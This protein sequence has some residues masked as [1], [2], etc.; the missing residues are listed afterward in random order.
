MTSSN[1]YGAIDIVGIR[2]SGK[3]NKYGAINVSSFK[4][5]QEE[6][7]GA[8]S[9]IRYASQFPGG[10]AEATT[11]GL[12]G[13]IW[14]MMAHGESE[15]D[16]YEEAALFE[17][18]KK[19]G[20]DFDIEEYEAERQN[21][22]ASLPTVGNISREVE[23]LTGLPL[24]PK[25]EGQELLRMGS[26]AGKFKSGGVLPKSTAA[27]A[28]PTT[29]AGLEYLGVPKEIAHPIG[30]L[31][32]ESVGRNVP[33]VKLG[34]I[35]PSGLSEK[36]YENLK[37][38]MDVPSS[39]LK[40]ISKNLETE[41]KEI[42]DK[43]IEETP[44]RDV[45]SAMKEGPAYKEKI[46]ERF[47]EVKNL[48]DELPE[49]F[50]SKAV[51]KQ[52]VDKLSEQKKKNLI[53]TE[54]EKA[55]N[56]IMKD[57]VKDFREQ[58]T[59]MSDIIQNYRELNKSR[60]D[61]FEPGKS[62]AHNEAKRK[63]YSDAAT[64]LSEVIET[65][66]PNSELN[67]L[68]KETNKEWSMIMD[69]ESIDTFIDGMF[70]GKI[71]FAKADKF[72]KKTGTSAPFERA[73]GKKGFNDFKQLMNDMM[74]KQK[75][76]KL[77]KEAED[78]GFFKSIKDKALAFMISD[79]VGYSKVAIDLGK[80]TR[81]NLK[82]YLLDKPKLITWDEFLKSMKEKDFPK[83]EKSFQKLVDQQDNT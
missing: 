33:D 39:K 62:Y 45:R 82:N 29:T 73:L 70:D 18:H 54:E 75:A 15:L 13:N 35:K 11:L 7:S 61:L 23:G 58:E 48:A 42:T 5:P 4:E 27:I 65:R 72:F 20:K 36:R 41:F 31:A 6:D 69:A 63:A 74:T 64:A 16:P 51:K 2:D 60:K 34:K 66:H 1:K 57:I 59:S 47:E 28:A 67:K 81:E 32:G 37:E 22:L 38:E 8:M 53:P 30:Y 49:K 9:A 40:N 78:K 14:Q 43:I 76:F 68:F 77:M 50:S 19:A 46:S 24:T 12:L 83:A 55:Y 26:S 52:L 44:I 25:T 3:N 80:A 71:N 10:I 17:A 21:A 79:T 56:S